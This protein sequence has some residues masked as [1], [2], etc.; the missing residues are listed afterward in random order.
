MVGTPKEL[1]LEND[2]MAYYSETNAL[3]G[4]NKLKHIGDLL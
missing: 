1:D 4:I 2:V 3:Y